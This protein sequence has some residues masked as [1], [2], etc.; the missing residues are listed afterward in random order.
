MRL[1]SSR[2][3]SPPIL[4]ALAL[5]TGATLAAGADAQTQAPGEAPDRLAPVHPDE[6][7]DAT[8][9][10]RLTL[11]KALAAVVEIRGAL[12]SFE[13]LTYD[14]RG[15]VDARRLAEIG[16]T[17]PETQTIGFHNLPGTVEGTLRLQEWRIR[18]L[19]WELAVE[20]RRSG[21]VGDAEV[22]VAEQA[23]AAADEAFRKFWSTF[24]I[25]D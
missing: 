9:N 10:D 2:T 15:R 13:Q 6:S 14:V 5:A 11:A 18:K 4:L 16:Y 25:A 3:L 1:G 21:R 7:V 8:L 23:F 19:A 20:Q 24:G 12:A 22:R 17:D